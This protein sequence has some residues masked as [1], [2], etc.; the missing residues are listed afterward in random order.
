MAMSKLDQVATVC[1]ITVFCFCVVCA[2]CK[3][4]VVPKW[5]EKFGTRHGGGGHGRQESRDGSEM[6]PRSPQV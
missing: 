6:T 3:N 1:G 5:V 2:F 4:V